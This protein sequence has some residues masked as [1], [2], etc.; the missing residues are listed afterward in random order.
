MESL[1][2]A[3]AN[4]A[5]A[6][7][8]IVT[9]KHVEEV[10][11]FLRSSLCEFPL[12]AGNDFPNIGSGPGIYFFDIQFPFRTSKDFLNF[13]D[14]WGSK[15]TANP[16]KSTSRAYPKR[17][18]SH[19]KK[20][21]AGEFVPFYVGKHKNVRSRVI[22]HLTGAAESGTYGL[23]LLSRAELLKGCKLRVSGITFNIAPDAY[24][25]M[26]FLEAALRERLHPMVGKQ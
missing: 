21:E 15:G 6:A 13:I 8:Q 25:S 12:V 20:V 19:V 22:Q 5:T 23:K 18:T 3:I 2:Q 14:M 9:P 26:E 24:F 4:T 7:K 1:L 16:Q 17:A 11:E 10:E